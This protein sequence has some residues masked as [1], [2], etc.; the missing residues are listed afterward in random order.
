M[1]KRVHKVLRE[2]LDSMEEWDQLDLKD[3][4]ETQDYPDLKDHPDSQEKL[5]HKDLPLSAQERKDQTQKLPE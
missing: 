3:H 2:F 4:G 5:D 1:P